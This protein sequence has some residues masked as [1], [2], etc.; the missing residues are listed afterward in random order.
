MRGRAAR[1]AACL[2][3]L[4]CLL[5]PVPGACL[6]ES[7]VR[8]PAVA[9]KFYVEEAEVLEAA[10]R[11]FLEDALPARGERPI[12]LVS[13]HAGYIY[14]GQIAA[15]AYRQAMGHEYDLIVL[16]GTNHTTP[17]FDGVSV[18]DG[19]GYKTP[20]GLARIDQG[21]AAALRKADTAFTFRPEVHQKEHSVEVQVPFAQVAFPGVPIVA[22]VIGRP[23]LELATRF[24]KALAAAVAER[25]ALIVASSDL[26]HYPAYDDAVAADRETLTAVASLDP[27]LVVST[28]QRQMRRPAQGLS[29][30]ACGEGPTLAAMIAA[31]ELG[32]RRGVVVSYANSGDV[33][34]GDRSRVVGYGAVAF[35]AGAGG[36]DVSVLA[37]P[38]PAK[39]GDEISAEGKAMLLRVARTTLERFFETGTTPLLRG[40]PQELRR[41]QGAFVT[42][43]KNGELRGCIGHMAEDT[44]L[45][46]V[47]GAMAINAAFRDRRFPQ[48]RPEELAQVEIEVSVLTPFRIVPDPDS[49]KVGRD[50][51]VLAKS[52][53]RSVFLPQVAPEQGWDR[54]TM[55]DR[56]CRKAGLPLACWKEG[57]RLSTFQADVFHEERPN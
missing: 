49:V 45:Y 21:V 47:V 29:T 44:P 6:D 36:T 18:Y 43:K 7:R 23:D 14:S 19:A 10:V 16:L 54:D 33:A 15:D 31:K 32:A 11:G 55:L 30:C 37:E 28:L 26:S 24:G 1:L 41:K 27:A 57:A 46:Q 4:L 48:L 13:P 56:L 5:A 38:K 51:V 12:A 25:K 53:K 42:L 39:P 2:G 40:F 50:G 9:G 34:I 22:A 20:L 3:L 17:R 8:F 52:G 35:T